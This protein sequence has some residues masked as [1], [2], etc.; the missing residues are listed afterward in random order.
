MSWLALLGQIA[1]SI[2]AGVT[3]VYL[4]GHQLYLSIGAAIA[5]VIYVL[6]VFRTTEAA[7]GIIDV[8]WVLKTSLIAFGLGLFWTAIP[9]VLVRGAERDAGRAYERAVHRAHGEEPP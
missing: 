3:G 1:L 9:I 4:L 8:W 6:M 2:G 7:P 5:V